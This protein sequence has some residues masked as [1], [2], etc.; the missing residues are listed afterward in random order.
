MDDFKKAL[1]QANNEYQM[2]GKHG[3][4]WCYMN[5]CRCESCRTAKRVANQ[6]YQDNRA[7]REGRFLARRIILESRRQKA[8]KRLRENRVPVPKDRQRPLSALQA[9]TA[10]RRATIFAVI[11]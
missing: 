8:L 4:V 1:S 9:G 11:L 3:T 7:K 6:R 2:K 5:G 10:S